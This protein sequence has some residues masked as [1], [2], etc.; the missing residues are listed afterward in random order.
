MSP[1]R[2]N[3]DL[4]ARR[5]AELIKAG[6]AEILEKGIQGV[7]LDAVVARAGAWMLSSAGEKCHAARAW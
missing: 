1:R 5:R 7:T 6:Y 3:P 4:A 2:P